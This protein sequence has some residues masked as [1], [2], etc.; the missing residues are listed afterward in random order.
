MSTRM[1]S[2]Q[3]LSG[4]CL[5]SVALMSCGN[6]SSGSSPDA[7]H[8]ATAATP[9]Q[10]EARPTADDRVCG[11]AEAVI[12][13]IAVDTARWSPDRHPFDVAVS[14]RLASRANDL[15]AQTQHAHSP[16]VKAAVGTAAKAFTEVAGAMS[17]KKRR[18]VE[19][20][21][22]AVRVVYRGL[23]KVCSFEHD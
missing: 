11:G 23:E 13:H 14:R 22:A 1:R 6:E 7:D 2:A 15:G 5:A 17:S 16:E 20:A 12:A 3:W 10:R 19:D 4:L 18:R 9:R 8:A 21:I